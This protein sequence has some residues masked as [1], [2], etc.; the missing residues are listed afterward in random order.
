MDQRPPLQLQPLRDPA[1]EV[2]VHFRVRMVECD[3]APEQW[4]SHPVVNM[5]WSGHLERARETGGVVNVHMDDE[6]PRHEYDGWVVGSLLRKYRHMPPR[7][8]IG[9]Y[10][11]AVHRNEHGSPCYVEV[12]TNHVDL[13]DIAKA[14]LKGEYVR[15]VEMRITPVTL[16]GMKPI[17]KAIIEVRVSKLQMKPSLQWDPLERS[18]LDAPAEKTDQALTLY[19]N[20]TMNLEAEL[21]DTFPRCERMRAPLDLAPVSVESTN[22]T[23]LPVAAFAMVPTP[24][25]NEHFFL[26]AITCVLD[27]RDLPPT[28]YHS[29]SLEERARTMAQVCSFGVQTFDYISD[30]IE[31]GNRLEMNTRHRTMDTDSFSNSWRTCSGDCEDGCRGIQCT[32]RAL[33]AVAAESPV[34]RDLQNLS[35]HYAALQMLTVVHGA[36]IG[37]EEGFGAHL[38][39][40]FVPIRKAEQMLEHTPQ[41]RQLL[42]MSKAP[43][44]PV[45]A[46]IQA[47]DLPVLIG[48]GTGIIDPLGYDHDPLLEE[49][50]YVA[51]GLPSAAP[52]KREIPHIRGQESTFYHG[53]L[54][55]IS[56]QWIDQGVGALVVGTPAPGKPHG[57]TRGALFTDVMAG[58][59]DR[60]ALMPQPRMPAAV[61]RIST[62]ALMLS[63]PPRPLK[64]EPA[65]LAR[66]GKDPLLDRLC[67]GIRALNHDPP[68]KKP[69]GSVDLFVRAHQ[70]DNNRID[71]L[72]GEASAMD[73][74]YDAEYV[75]EPIVDRVT[76]YR[77]RL[78]V[79]PE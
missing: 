9:M 10:L 17:K 54:L 47:Q 75:E 67:A 4:E 5:F 2:R 30:T 51:C 28:A 1:R 49:R 50:K 46:S 11:Y 68:A 48:E 6:D 26:N 32:L 42:Q 31:L 79:R 33:K 25:A 23:F 19:V 20:A 37:D 60:V 58:R 62:E 63:P 52:F 21:H 22:G 65:Q 18:A 71:A 69:P 74:L 57:M 70:Y 38:C 59:T 64:L 36:K 53:F 15:P 39:D 40:V 73:R 77:V 14:L 41:G 24:D 44:A 61:R 66:T 35:S 29:M 3:L 72:L 78:W 34:L 45:A 27:R 55:A 12:G 7:A 8:A 16:T 13:R 43:V 76:S 56:D